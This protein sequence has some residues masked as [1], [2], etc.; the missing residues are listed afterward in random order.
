MSRIACLVVPRFPVAALLRS[1][2]ELRGAAL[3][4]SDPASAGSHLR[5]ALVGVSREA[6]RL[7]IRR[8]MTVAQA[9][10]R[11]ADLL[12]R[13]LDLEALRAAHEALVEVAASVSP[14]V[15][16][17]EPLDLR[18]LRG[19]ATPGAPGA[20]AA[21]LG[22]VVLDA[23]GLDRLFGSPAG[24]AAALLARSER[25]GLEGGVGIADRKATARIA[26]A[27]AAARGEAIVVPPAEDAAWLAPLPLAA[28][29]PILESTNGSPSSPEA[30]RSGAA[31]TRA[32][33]L[34]WPAI[35]ETLGLLGVKQLG[36]LAHLPPGEVASRFGPLG[37]LAWRIAAGEDRSPL[38]PRAVAPETSEG[39]TLDYGLASLEA[40]LFVVR[41]LVDRITA[42]LRLY[43]LACRELTIALGLEDG[44]RYERAVGVLAP[45]LD[46]KA[47]TTL[48]CLAIEA[49]PPRAAIESI[50]LIATPDRVRP[51]QL[52]LFRAPGPAPAELATTLARLAALCGPD[53]VGRPVAPS[54][55]RPD[56]WSL[57]PFRTAEH[58]GGDRPAPREAANGG[59]AHGPTNSLVLRA[60]RP[61][62]PA[63][64]FRE[65]G[66]VAYVRAAGLGGR[67]V[68]ASGPWRIE[69]EWWNDPPLG[70]DYYD[71]ELSD[72]GVYRLYRDLRAADESTAWFIDGCYD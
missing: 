46:V 15:E 4:V 52:D 11:H 19:R 3:V 31:S 69:G 45:T 62:R 33:T 66:E 50:R 57:A 37:A 32:G 39:A 72:G 18:P 23:S 41:G 58:D 38:A 24:I 70:R 27:R 22:R 13:R 6:E 65:R 61:P 42:R 48:T 54:G 47:L 56:A 64:V 34:A 20:H 53:R 63:Q 55:Y 2:P 51:F 7:G 8:G 28:L 49:S 14:R 68:A 43:G 30:P 12:V 9:I 25:I 17:D 10:A 36:D 40:L 29:A 60:I 26:A 59:G 5:A 44:G 1:E 71:V 35:A 21:S 67:A 16:A